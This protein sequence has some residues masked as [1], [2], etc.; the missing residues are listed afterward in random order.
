MLLTCFQTLQSEFT[1][2]ETSRE[3]LD[4]EVVL[5]SGVLQ[6]LLRARIN[7]SVT[8]VCFF[9]F[10]CSMQLGRTYLQKLVTVFTLY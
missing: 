8:H 4:V 3:M 6:K 9:L 10:S 1:V 5:R 2:R 7:H